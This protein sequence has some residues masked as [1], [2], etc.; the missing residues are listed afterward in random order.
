M[1]KRWLKNWLGITALEA[2][3]QH[4]PAVQKTEHALIAEWTA[5]RDALPPG[6]PKHTALTNR[7]R[8]LGV[9]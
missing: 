3:M 7:L 8:S 6:S 2:A 9:E 4:R 1:L 5:L